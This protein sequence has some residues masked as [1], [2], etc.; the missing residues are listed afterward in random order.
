MKARSRAWRIVAGGVAVAFGLG[1]AGAGA[2]LW[3]G[4]GVQEQQRT[5]Q[6]Q[7]SL[8]AT[9][10]PGPPVADPA[11]A[12]AVPSGAV[13]AIR[14]PRLGYYAAV[15]EGVGAAVLA[16]GPG[17]YPGTAWPGQEGNV[18][19]AAHNTFWIAFDRLA[20]GDEI[21]VETRTGDVGYRVLGG[22]VVDPSDRTVLAPTPGRSRLTLTTCW[23]LWAGALAPRRL[24]IV[25]EST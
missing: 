5:R 9:A 10:A 22:R 3:L 12:P 2:W 1:L 24:A 14:I 16:G 21:V 4:A 15:S 17:H 7:E 13:F 23:P 20:V 11:T 25:A 8:H 6:W 18:G 19:V